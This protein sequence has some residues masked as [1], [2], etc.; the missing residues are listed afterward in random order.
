MIGDDLLALV[1]DAVPADHARQ[2]LAD[3]WIETALEGGGSRVLDLGCG[4]GDS[5]DQFRSVDPSVHW[6]GVDLPS[7]PEVARRAR[8]DA[9]FHTFDGERLPFEDGS[10]DFVYCKQVLEHVRRPAVLLA[11]VTRVLAPGG[12]LAGSTSQLEAFHSLSTWNYTPYGLKLLLEDT[13]MS[14]EELR[15]GIDSLT[16]ILNRGLG[17]PRVTR[18]YWGR[19]SPLNRAISLFGRVRGLDV[20]HVNAIKLLFCGQF[21]FLAR[22]P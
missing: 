12:V 11:D 6:V 20:E 15:P 17:M 16:L 4:T 21:A 10:F 9:E 22:R 19:E 2:V 3:H 1:H 18:R 7:S 13:G 8:T 14:L 5:V